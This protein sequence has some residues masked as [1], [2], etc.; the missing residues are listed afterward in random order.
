M[1]SIFCAP[2]C[3]RMPFLVWFQTDLKM[4][5]QTFGEFTEKNFINSLKCNKIQSVVVCCV[6]N[7][8][9]IKCSKKWI[10]SFETTAQW[11]LFNHKKVEFT[12]K[13]NSI[14]IL[15]IG[16]V[17]SNSQFINKEYEANTQHVVYFDQLLSAMSTWKLIEIQFLFLFQSVWSV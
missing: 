1:F 17:I 11:K 9:Q 4:Q 10:I 2:K 12:S 3:T 16:N 14:F 13:C 7:K 6:R 8:R 15:F 5:Q